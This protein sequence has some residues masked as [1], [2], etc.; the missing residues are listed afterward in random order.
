MYNVGKYMGQIYYVRESSTYKNYIF[1]ENKVLEF[2]VNGNDCVESTNIY[3]PCMKYMSPVNIISTLYT[4]DGVNSYIELAYNYGTVFGKYNI[5]EEQLKLCRVF[6]I[7]INCIATLKRQVA[8]GVLQTIYVFNTLET[9]LF[10]N[11]QQ[12]KLKF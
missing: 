1:G 11:L 4:T 8:K 7:H 3:L 6:G 12:G 10:Q 9:D 5:T 2:D